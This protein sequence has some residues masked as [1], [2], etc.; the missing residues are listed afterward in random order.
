MKK[1]LVLV[2][3]VA[4]IGLPCTG[5]AV[6]FN[7]LQL[8][9]SSLGF[10]YKQMNV[11]MQGRFRKFSGQI[12]F[13]P[14]KAASAT[15]NFDVELASIDTGSPEG[16]DAVA[17]K[18]WFNTRAFPVA[19]FASS[20]VTPLAGNRYEV[21]GELSIKGHTQA[22]SAPVTVAI[23]DHSATFDGAFVLKRA[24]FAIGEGPWAD[25]GVV[26]NEIQISFHIVAAGGQ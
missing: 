1:F 17:G 6:E 10:S 7:A 5:W 26:A 19:R 13:D 22:L 4:A 12:R 15:V 20:R 18:Q 14:A 21:A 3:L 25:Y 2:S 23:H 11:P 9:Q 24:D 8:D 16:D